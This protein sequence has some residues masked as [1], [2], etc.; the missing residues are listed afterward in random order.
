MATELLSADEFEQVANFYLDADD[1]SG[2]CSVRVDQMLESRREDRS[3]GVGARITA[4]LSQ[5]RSVEMMAKALRHPCEELR[6]LAQW[7]Y[8]DIRRP[9]DTHHRTPI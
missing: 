1:G 3:K 2:A 9:S 7:L 4:R 6:D 5:T 8:E